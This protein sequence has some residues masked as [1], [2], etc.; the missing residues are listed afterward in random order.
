MKFTLVVI[1]III[2]CESFQT[3][4]L[5]ISQLQKNPNLVGA[6]GW[7]KQLLGR[8]HQNARSQFQKVRL[9]YFR[10]QCDLQNVVF[11]EKLS[12]LVEAQVDIQQKK[13]KKKVD[14]HAIAN[15]DDY[16]DYKYEIF[17]GDR[18][19]KLLKALNN[20]KFL[21]LYPGEEEVSLFFFFFLIFCGGFFFL[22][23]EYC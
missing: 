15:P 2:I 21:S 10:F 5:F 3:R 13:K 12:N 23:D 22:V 8:S 1:I 20:A 9:S 18:V 6:S 17:Y 7:P 16:W 19:F 11:L 4:C 14:I